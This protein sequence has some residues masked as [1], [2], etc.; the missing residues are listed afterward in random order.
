MEGRKE[1]G[2]NE[3]KPK[4]KDSCWKEIWHSPFFHLVSFFFTN[5]FKD[6]IPEI[7]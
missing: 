2:G 7:F 6:T 1:G 4:E 5:S 3:G